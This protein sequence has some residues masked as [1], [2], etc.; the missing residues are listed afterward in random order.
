MLAETD[1]AENQ[2]T[3]F[4]TNTPEMVQGL[5]PIGI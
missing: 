5:A 2:E 1:I 4:I 3:N